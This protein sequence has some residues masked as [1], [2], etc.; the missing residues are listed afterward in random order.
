MSPRQITISR[1]YLR[2]VTANTLAVVLAIGLGLLAVGFLPGRSNGLSFAASGIGAGVVASVIVYAMVS[3][4]LDPMRQREQITE[5][6]D[7]VNELWYQQFYRRFEEWL[8]EA[9]Y[10]ASEVLRSDFQAQFARLLRSSDRYDFKGGTASHTTFRL[11]VL[12][13]H[14]DIQR[15][16]EVRLCLFDPRQD[17][18]MRAFAV[19]LLQQR[20]LV[21]SVEAIENETQRIRTAIYRSVIAL[22]DVRQMVSTNLFFHGDLPFV[23]VEMFDEGMMLTYY[24]ATA[25]YPG[26]LQ[27]SKRSA[28]YRAYR[29]N[30]DLTCEFSTR[31]LRFGRIG[32]S[33]DLVD[34][35]DGLIKAL[36]ELGCE[37]DLGRLRD[38]KEA[39]L[40]QSLQEVRDAHLSRSDL[41]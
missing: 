41:F 3:L 29:L 7:D 26:A 37:E 24:Q 5:L 27:F 8:P 35:D 13:N 16:H 40:R 17:I 36:R 19:Q 25:K 1:R 9:T 6:I 18:P 23:R 11:A 38:A 15:L 2:L 21:I 20:H 33:A 12:A 4:R 31:V 34:T 30:I 22:Y 10:P 14:P 39:W 28:S 32:P